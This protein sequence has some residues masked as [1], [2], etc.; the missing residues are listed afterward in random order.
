[1]GANL[2]DAEQ[3]RGSSLAS[4]AQSAV[5]AVDLGISPSWSPHAPLNMEL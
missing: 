5:G 3:D 2:Q 1:M 4:R